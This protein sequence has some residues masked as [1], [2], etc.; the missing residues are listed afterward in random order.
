MG[1]GSYA[2][3][4]VRL[5]GDAVYVKEQFDNGWDCARI[6]VRLCESQSSEKGCLRVMAE[7]DGTRT[8]QAWCV[9]MSLPARNAEKKSKRPDVFT[10]SGHW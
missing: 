6:R 5:L 2:V 8:K 9:M 1:A 3:L 4:F 10:T 7:G